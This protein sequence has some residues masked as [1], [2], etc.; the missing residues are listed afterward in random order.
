MGQEFFGKVR[1][2][3]LLSILLIVIAAEHLFAALVVTLN[4]CRVRL[5]K[6]GSTLRGGGRA[7]DAWSTELDCRDAATAGCMP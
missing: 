1:I 5:V 3:A 7:Q 6:V 2:N 4:S